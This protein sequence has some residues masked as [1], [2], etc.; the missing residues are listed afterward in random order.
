MIAYITTKDQDQA[1]K[2][3]IMLLM[4]RLAACA[5][6]IKGIKSFYWWKGE[7]TNSS[8]CAV[9]AKTR[10]EHME[11]IVKK[12]KAMHTYAIPCI[13]FLPIEGGSPE[14]LKWLRSETT[15]EK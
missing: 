10:R 2:I 9:I 7:I 15:V 5:N 12:V 8:E 13:I 6:I 14:F 3:S 11:K 4:E 1:E